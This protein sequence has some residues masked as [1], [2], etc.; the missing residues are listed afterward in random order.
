MDISFI[1]A[2][3]AGMVA[4]FNP[5]GAAM[6]PAYVG[7]QLRSPHEAENVLRLCGKGLLLG[8]SV[9]GGFVCVFGLTGVIF[10]LGGQLLGNALPFVGLTIGILITFTGIVLLLAPRSLE[11]P[12]LTSISIGSNNR[13]VDTFYFGIAYALASLSCALPIF[14]AAIGLVVGTG[15][16]MESSSNII[17]GTLVYCIGMG[18]VMTLVTLAALFFEESVSMFM[19]RLIPYVGLLG[20]VAMIVAGLYIMS[21]WII[22]DGSELLILRLESLI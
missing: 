15:I 13:H 16:S 20:R 18:I 12:V 3:T 9:T 19:N 4:A 5:C 14:L 21:Y 22:G 11:V 8:G 6:F 7:F 1:F 2:L 17:I 10:S